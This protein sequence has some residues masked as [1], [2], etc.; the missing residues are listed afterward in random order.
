MKKIL[1]FSL[2]LLLL[3][4]TF[5]SCKENSTGSDSEFN[6]ASLEKQFVWNAMNYWYFWQND[7]P[8]LADDQGF[9]ES[10]QDYHD[11]LIDFADAEAVFNDLLFEEADDFSFFISNYETFLQARQGVSTDF[12]F[13]FGLVQPDKNSSDLFGYVQYVLPGSPAA[14]AGLNRGDIFT[15]INGSRLTVNNYRQI[16]SNSSYELTM[17]EYV[18]EQTN[19]NGETVSIQATILEEDPILI[20]KVID[21]GSA[22]VGYLLYNSFQLNSHQ[23]LN[24]VFGDFLSEGIDELVLDLRYNGGGTV[25]TADILA[26]LISGI[27]Q[28]NTF[29]Q[30]TF[31]QKRS[32]SNRSLPFLDQVLLY[33]E[34][35]QLTEQIDMNAIGLDRVYILTGFGTASASESVI[36]GLHPFLDVILIGDQTVGKDDVSYTLFDTSIPPYLEIE[37]ARSNHKLAL[38]PIVGKAVNANGESNNDGFLPKDDLFIR[39]IDYLDDLPPLGETNEPLLAKAIELITGQPLAK[40]ITIP[41]PFPGEMF[42]DS[43]DLEKFAKEMYL[44][45]GEL[46]LNNADSQQPTP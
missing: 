8:E 39:E 31:N 45:P 30:Y 22:K 32:G 21:T 3:S 4:V 29:I 35:Q 34:N 10:G 19:E 23:R 43:R 15:A 41:S 9:F 17:A 26:S 7:V 1:R 6:R 5:W 16:L 46:S 13:E 18:E 2:V 27:G 37:N 14:D 44:V 20:S 28:T 11:Y 25:V 24:N 33:D 38:Q 40:S 42:K 12:G 36:N